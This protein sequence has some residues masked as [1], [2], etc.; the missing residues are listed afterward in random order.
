MDIKE[1]ALSDAGSVAACLDLPLRLH[2]AAPAYVPPLRLFQRRRLGQLREARLRLFCARAGG[3]VVGTASLLFDARHNQH[4][5]ATEA[6]FGFFE[7]ADDAIGRALLARVQAEARAAGA[8]RLIGPRNLSRVE[9]I[10]LLIEG[11]QRRPPML[12]GYHPPRYQGVLEAAGFTRR[13]DMLAYETDLNDA[14]GRPRPLPEGLAQKAAAAREAL[15]GLSIRRVGWS[16]QEL[17]DAH[18]VFTAAYADVPEVV[19]MSLEQF[20]SLGRVF[21]LVANHDLMQLARMPD[22]RPVA[23]AVCLPDL[24]QALHEARA[25]QLSVDGRRFAALRAIDGLRRLIPALRRITTASFKLIGVVP[26]LRHSGL[27]ALLI[28]QVL[29]GLRRAGYERLEAS[30]IHEDNL[31]MR[32][33]V[34][35]AGLTVY[36]RYRIFQSELA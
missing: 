12:A 34:E 3:E 4:R 10:G 36:Q 17:R 6:F 2:A 18:A 21:L 5:G 16:S 32:R 1:V 11:H 23:M 19:P 8:A 20:L 15:G 33:V 28:D 27:H 26:D 9:D 25:P 30:L 13:Y 7:C 14:A 29:A 24:N 31:P 22:G 35:G